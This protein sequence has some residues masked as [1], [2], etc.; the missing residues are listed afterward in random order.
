[1]F[2][3]I[4]SMSDIKAFQILQSLYCQDWDEKEFQIFSKQL[5]LLAKKRQ[6]TTSLMRQFEET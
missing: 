3:E 6:L 1:M 2:F 4:V 5:V